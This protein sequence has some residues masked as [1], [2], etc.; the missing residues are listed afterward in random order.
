MD[1]DDSRVPQL[2]CG[3]RLALKALQIVG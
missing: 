2:R 3:P 1:G